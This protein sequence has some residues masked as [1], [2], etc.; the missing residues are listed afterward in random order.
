MPHVPVPLSRPWGPFPR[1][2]RPV[3][4]PKPQA[5]PPGPRRAPVPLGAQ[6]LPHAGGSPSPLPAKPEPSAWG[7]LCGQWARRYVLVGRTPPQRRWGPPRAQPPRGQQ[8]DRC[9]E[10][11]GQ[12]HPKGN[13]QRQGST[14][15]CSGV[16]AGRAEETVLL[17]PRAE[18]GDP[19]RGHLP[20]QALSADTG[21]S[22]ET[23]TSSNLQPAR[24]PC[25]EW[26]PWPEPDGAPPGGGWRA[27][28]RGQMGHVP[29]GTA[30]KRRRFPDT[31][32]AFL[33]IILT[34]VICAHDYTTSQWCPPP[35]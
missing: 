27:Q 5:T 32:L 35:L 25:S 7:R 24:P 3:P 33:M 13:C 34:S 1:G 9:P 17:P 22:R 12:L 31:V 19:L 8:I 10:D 18:G 2:G 21:V 29:G 11:G 14:G 28:R 6:A 30:R 20:G 23:C 26:C 16:E 4:H 15:D